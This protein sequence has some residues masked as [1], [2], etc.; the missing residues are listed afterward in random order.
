[1]SGF[2]PGISGIGEDVLMGNPNFED[3]SSDS[4]DTTSAAA[5][6]MNF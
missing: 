5:G 2:I 3:Y 1:L 4:F 6:E